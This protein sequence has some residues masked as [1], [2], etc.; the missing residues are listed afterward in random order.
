MGT[1]N[2]PVPSAQE[3]AALTKR[4]LMNN[5]FVPS[6]V[7]QDDNPIP[8]RPGVA[9]QQIKHIIFINKE[10]ATHDLILGDITGTRNGAPVKGDPA[11]SLGYAATPH[12]HEL[13]LR[14]VFSDN[15]FLEPAVSSDGHRWLTDTYSTEF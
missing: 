5:G 1:V 4:V 14:F 6:T 8:S 12:H 9:S 11:F 10:N 15:F 13:A 7:P 2:F 3:L